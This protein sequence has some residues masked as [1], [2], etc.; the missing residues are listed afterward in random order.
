MKLKDFRSPFNRKK[1]IFKMEDFGFG[2]KLAYSN[3]DRFINKDGSFNIHREGFE[4]ANLYAYLVE[5]SWSRFVMLIFAFYISINAFFALLYML[6]GI[7]S[8]AGIHPTGFITDFLNAFFFSIQTFTTVGYGAIHPT[9]I[10]AN[11]LATFGALVGLMSFA[12]ATGLFFARFSQPIANIIYS[13]NALIAPYKEASSFQFR[14]V[15]SRDHK[16]VDLEA[17][18]TMTWLEKTNDGIN[19]R[20]FASLKLERNKIFLFPLNWTIV[21]PIDKESPLYGKTKEYVDS[22]KVEFLVL[23]KGYDKTFNQTIH[24]S[25]SYTANEL[26]WNAQFKTMYYPDKKRGTILELDKIDDLIED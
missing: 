11:I 26:R 4:D 20:R 25:T 21:H 2:D 3:E 19:H 1:P 8:L 14:I 5:I 16:L 17:I 12:L 10:A 22:A 9:N 13:K 7:E 6:I 18:I 15:N 24:S 23:I